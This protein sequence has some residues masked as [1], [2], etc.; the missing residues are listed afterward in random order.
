MIST[1]LAGLL[2]HISRHSTQCRGSESRGVH[3][4]NL[5]T[6][7]LSARKFVLE[8]KAFQRQPCGLRQ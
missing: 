1:F 4:R 7:T 2:G 6:G 3:I 8:I 5:G